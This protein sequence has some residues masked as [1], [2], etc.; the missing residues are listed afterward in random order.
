M[1]PFERDQRI[2]VGE[3][4]LIDQRIAAN[5]LFRFQAEIAG[6]VRIEL[7]SELLK[8]ERL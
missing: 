1:R 7:I 8:T 3:K 2:G 4:S 5:F 6:N